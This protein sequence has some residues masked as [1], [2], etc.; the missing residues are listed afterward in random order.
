MAALGEPVD[1]VGH[2][3]GGSTVVG[4]AMA[5][6]DLLRTWASDSLGVFDPDY[7]WHGLAREWQTPG[8]GEKAIAEWMGGSADDRVER[9]VA[10][11][12]SRPVAARLADAQGPQM[13]RAILAFYRSAAQ[14]VMADLGRHLSAAAERPGLA[15]LGTEDPF[16][17][18]EEMRRRS[19]ARAGAR[20]ATLDGLGHYWMVQDPVRS[21][22]VLTSFWAE[23]D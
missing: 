19:A 9:M 17:G 18:S 7:E 6:P 13:G 20:V 5:R 21:A 22:R 3:V 12:L 16:V 2:D 15:I 11:G 8:V 10:V 14:P 1:L 4:V 23:H